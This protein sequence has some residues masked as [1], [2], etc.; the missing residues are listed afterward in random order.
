MADDAIV[1][2]MGISHKK[3]TRPD[4]RGAGRGGAAVKRYAFTHDAAGPQNKARSFAAVFQVL[5][6][7]TDKGAR[8]NLAAFADLGKFHDRVRSQRDSRTQRYLFAD[9]RVRSDGCRGINL[10][11]GM[12]YS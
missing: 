5:G 6:S 4:A 9:H 11:R 8:V 10:R 3:T 2:D 1:S 7:R 12:D